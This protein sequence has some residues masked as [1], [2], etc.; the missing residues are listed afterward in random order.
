MVEGDNRLTPAAQMLIRRA[1]EA[2]EEG[3][4]AELGLN[5]WLLAV[6]TRHSMMAES[7]A[8]GLEST[9]LKRHVYS[10]LREGDFGGELTKDDAVEKA[11]A[12]AKR[13]GR[14]QA[15]E[16]DLASVVLIAVG[17]KVAETSP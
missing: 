10:R 13:L 2:R 4:F 5:H 7:L 8:P 15:N 9:P 14:D 3:K 16:K 12:W 17:Y 11:L 6:L 1:E